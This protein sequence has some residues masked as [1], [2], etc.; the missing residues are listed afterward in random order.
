MKTGTWIV[1]GVLA[2]LFLKFGPGIL[3]PLIVL[4]AVIFVHEYGHYFFMVRN[5]VKVTE[6][7]I[8][9]GPT[10][11]EKQLKSGTYFRLKPLLL[12]GYA[13]PVAGDEE[14]S[15]ERASLWAKF[16]IYMGG[17]LFNSMTAFVC[18]LVIFYVQ[19]QAPSF[20]VELVTRAGVPEG[21][22]RPLACAFLMSFGLWLATPPL[23]IMIIS[24]GFSALFNGMSGPLG[25]LE[26]GAAAGSGDGGPVT[27]LMAVLSILSFFAMINVAVAGMNLLPL[28]QLD[29]GRIIFDL[30]KRL[31]GRLGQ[32]LSSSYALISAVLL[33]GLILLAVF[34]D[35]IKMFLR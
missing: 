16:K 11:W 28:M 31:P 2:L 21:L 9:F 22:L 29:G 17:M 4:G 24:K 26:M 30:L 3:V 6:F 20:A 25:I 33:I 34:G 27:F 15:I 5:G 35:V 10:I 14:G 23:F 1:L 8:G 7:T 12:G 18:Y 13:K 32:A 19:R